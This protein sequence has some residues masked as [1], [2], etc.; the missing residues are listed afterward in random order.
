[1]AKLGYR[2]TKLLGRGGF[3]VVFGAERTE[4]GS[5][6]AIKLALREQ[7]DAI[8]SLTR[9]LA[10]LRTVGPPHVP[11]VYDSGTLHEGFYV[12]MER[13][14]APTLADRMIALAGPAP[15]ATFGEL[16]HAIMTP[17]EAI[18]S[19]GIIHRDLK[20]ENIF[21]YDT[22]VARLID[23][24][25]ARQ[26]GSR[27]ENIEATLAADDVGTA[28]YMSPEQCDGL[29]E[30]DRSSD[31]YSLGVLFYE[32][33]TGAPPFWGRAADVREAHR[34]RR[35]API[36]LKVPCPRELDQ[37]VR[38][39]LAKDRA[40]RFDD[41]AQ[42][43]QALETSLV[44]R[45]PSRSPVP[46]PTEPKSAAPARAAPPPSAAREKRAMGLVFFESRTGLSSVQAVVVAAGGQI[47]QTNGSQYVAAFGHDVGDNPARIALVAANRL[48]TSKLSQRLLVDVATVSVQNRPDGS[49]RIFSSVL[50]KSDRYP[51]ATDPIG[52]MLT[53]AASEVLPDLEAKVVDG[54]ADRFVLPF[55]QSQNE[56]TTFGSQ[57]SPLVGRDEELQNLITSAR[58][59]ASEAKP[60]LITVLG[61]N[62]YGRTHLASIAAHELARSSHG[63]KVIRLTAQEGIVSSVSQ[64]FPELL[65]RLLD[66]PVEVPE[67]GGKPL[68]LSLL[69]D[70]GENVWAGAAHALGWIDADHPEVRRLASAPGALR[71]AAARAA[72]EALRRGAE[73]KP[74]ALLLDDA[75][76]ADEATLDALEY[77]TL[78]DVPARVW[79]CVL[80]RPSFAGGRP[81]WGSRAAIAHKFVL[82]ELTTKHAAELAR[83]LLLPAEYIPEAVLLRLAERT[84]GV[85]RLLVELV[86]GLKRDGF[87]RRAERGTGYTLAIEE[88]DKLP[89]LPILQWNA[90]REIEALP[91]Q[92]AGHARLAS[93]LGAQF[94]TSEIEALLQ[95]LEREELPEDMQLDASVGVQRLV[96][97]GILVRHRNGRVDFRH[98]LLRD[99]I[100]QLVPEAQRARLHRAA[101][102]AY[103][104]LALPKDQRLPRLAMH[105]ARCGEREI[106]ANAYLE[107]AQRYMRVQ[108]YLEA[109]A[110]YGSALDNLPEDDERTIDAA[111]GRG[112]MRSR[113][114]RQE[115]ALADLRRARERAHAR[116]ATEREI[117][118]MLDE[119]TVLDWTREASQSSTLVRA[120][121]AMHFALSPL[122]HARLAMG[123]ARSHHR[124][125]EAEATVRVGSEAIKLAEELGDEGYET[126]IIAQ[127]MVATD[128]ANSGRLEEAERSFDQLIAEAESRGDLWHVAAALGNRAVLWHGLKDLDR[129]FADLARTAQ[130]GREIGE[131]S[132]EFVAVYNLAES[133]YV[134]GRLASAREHA[135]RGLELSKQLFGDINR[136]VSVSELL[137]ARIA[138]YEDDLAAAR[139]LARNIRER[140]ARGLAAGETEAELEPPLQLLLE[141]I[142]L[143]ANEAPLVAWQALVA[144]SRT[145]ELQPMEEVE[146]LER[147]AIRSAKLGA[148]EDGRSLYEQAMEVSKLKPNLMSERV[149]RKLAPLFELRSV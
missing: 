6:V 103:R 143:A 113:L 138:L 71:L 133:E 78:K 12:V 29:P 109:E 91:P 99:T 11:A 69:G 104:A 26:A 5:P 119:A 44:A 7:A 3:G 122:L 49:K 132:I 128:C 83:R 38:R 148:L 27:P 24:G 84:Q 36:S 14:D 53:A 25:L 23:F 129:L 102:E 141:M 15:L 45:L 33:L 131:A 108:A 137:L 74:I 18:H 127:L 31:I 85:P 13:I 39:C 105:A 142:E 144:R 20:P 43:R 22:G 50:T 70:A 16:A 4:D 86:R 40:Q 76:L 118:L 100:Y 55:Q 134:L 117:E 47:V 97:S 79:V 110:A 46:I 8:E 125:G 126:R 88:L 64:V 94:S 52:V 34:S 81:S 77:A 93:V 32:L 59:A 139:E 42:L 116:L 135:Q 51:I 54:R 73:Q 123:L 96:D 9:E 146:L 115:L 58:R 75:H 121:E 90:I 95:V 145:L 66:L 149:V 63:L 89:D 60:T 120:V 37:L 111:R 98:A 30:T 124:Q 130:L 65:R 67:R 114:G 41:V 19:S 28:E 35:P 48:L 68:L 72:G 147:A 56:L 10:A 57:V 140:T 62:G 21:V 82:N 1:L 101:F 92:L 80:A 87:V 106:A 112:L 107:L 136:E 2:V 17:L 61:A